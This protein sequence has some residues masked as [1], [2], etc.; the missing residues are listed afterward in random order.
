MSSR[1][2]DV[3]TYLQMIITV[4]IVVYLA[5]EAI[6]AYIRR[7]SLPPGPR[8]Y[9]LVGNALQI[10]SKLLHI[11]LAEWANKYGADYPPLP[12]ECVLIPSKGPMFSLDL[13][14]QHVVVISSHKVAMDLLGTV[15]S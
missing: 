1:Q 5:A 10:P 9:P 3:V 7:R 11:H 14:G 4:L 12:R 6:Q 2:Y 13:L 8:R 15:L